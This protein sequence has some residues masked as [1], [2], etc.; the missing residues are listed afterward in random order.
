MVMNFY[1]ETFLQIIPIIIFGLFGFF[2]LIGSISWFSLL[3]YLYRN[4]PKAWKELTIFGFFPSHKLGKFLWNNEDYDDGFILKLKKVSR[5]SFLCA[6]GVWLLTIVVV[7]I[8]VAIGI[9][10]GN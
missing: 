5:Y 9:L 8:I 10:F 7:L 6:I 3:I 2:V 4:K 1:I